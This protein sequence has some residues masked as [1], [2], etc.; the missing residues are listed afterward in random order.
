MMLIH[1]PTALLPMDL[2]C[3][4]LQY[5][6]HQPSFAFAAYYAQVA[7]VGAGWVAALAG[8]ADLAAI[9]ASKTGAIRK[10]V[11]HGGINVSVLMAYTV[12]AYRS[13]QYYPALPEAT[14]ALLV[15]KGCLLALMVIGN[16]LGGSLILK[17]KIGIET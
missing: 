1:F 10:A 6:T 3:Y 17:D 7:A 5:Y 8:V 12:V 2:V 16:F 9:P 14:I 15:L 13:Y 11:Y 4:G